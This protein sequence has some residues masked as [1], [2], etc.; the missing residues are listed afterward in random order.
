MKVGMLLVFQNWHT[1]PELTDEQMVMG[2]L[3]LAERAEGDGYES[4]WMVEHHFDS[5]A[6]CPDNF[7]LLSYLAGRTEKIQLGTGA[8]I[9]PWNDPLRVAEKAVLLDFLTEGRSLLGMGRGLSPMEYDGFGIDL[10]EARERFDEA[11]RMVLD[12]LEKGEMEGPGPMYPQARVDLRPRPNESRP[13]RD[14]AYSVGQSPASIEAIA[15]LGTGLLT[16]KQLPDSEHAE[17][18]ELHRD[19][20]RRN[21]GREAPAPIFAEFACVHEDP[22]TVG[23]WARTYLNN[24]GLSA[25]DHYGF[26]DVQRWSSTRGYEHYAAGAAVIADAGAQAGATAYVEAQPYGSPEEVIEKIAKQREVLGDFELL[27][28]FSYGGMPLELVDENYRLF[29][30]KVLPALQAL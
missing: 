29:N 6:M 8:V 3:R 10:N 28:V 11:A 26:G 4:I 22:D 16:F 23:E 13:F 1:D 19:I 7:Q 5:Y 21:H 2:D 18:V 14:R 20:F 12:G 27:M 15:E 9:L 30:E 25:M 17:Q 24:Y